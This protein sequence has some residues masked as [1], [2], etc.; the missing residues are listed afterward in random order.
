[1]G[2]KPSWGLVCN[3]GAKV[4][5][6]SLDTIGWFA[7]SAGDVSLVLDALAPAPAF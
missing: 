3:E 5:A 4:F 7:R 1:M 6:P 2:F